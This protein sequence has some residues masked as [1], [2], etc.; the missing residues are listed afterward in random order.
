MM[1]HE[2]KVIVAVF[3][4]CILVFLMGCFFRGIEP[5]KPKKT[6][7]CHNQKNWKVSVFN[8]RLFCR[9]CYRDV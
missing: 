1:S 7:C 4:Y 9:V 5:K 8:H 6:K 3:A 2:Q